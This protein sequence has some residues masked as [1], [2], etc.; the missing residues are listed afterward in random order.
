MIK[1]FSLSKNYFLV[2]SVAIV[3]WAMVRFSS[4]QRVKLYH[5]MKLSY[6]SFDGK[7]FLKTS[8]SLL[9]SI[10]PAN[11]V[12]LCN[13]NH[14]PLVATLWLLRKYLSHTDPKKSFR[15]GLLQSVSTWPFTCL[16]TVFNGTPYVLCASFIELPPSCTVLMALTKSLYNLNINWNINED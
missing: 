6:H 9:E 3:L 2:F 11:C 15:P 8:V 7:A 13:S 14:A 10:S 4:C 16:Q 5:I 12:L 1:L